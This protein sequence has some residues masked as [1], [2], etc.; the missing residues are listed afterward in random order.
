MASYAVGDLQGCNRELQLLLK[1]IG[2]RPGEDRLVLLGDLVNRGPES[3]AVLRWAYAHREQVEVVLGNHDLHLIAVHAGCERVKSRDTFA[4]VLAAQDAPQLIAW[5]RTQPLARV[6]DERF[7]CVHAGVLPVWSVEEAL[8]LSQEV[9]SVLASPDYKAFLPHLYGNQPDTWDAGLQG[10]PRLRL[11]VNA[12][13]RMRVLDKDGRLELGFKGELADAPAGLQAW[14]DAPH[15][16]PGHWRVLF[17]HWSALGLLL[18]DDVVSLDTGCA[19][20]RSLS[21]LRLD[22]GAVF[23]VPSLQPLHSE[24][25]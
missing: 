6:L 19:W 7:L 10:W 21:A 2:F 17:G 15:R 5:L 4:D 22:D 8:R 12:M 23:Q 1:R 24:K 20:G 9:S 3:L 18:R 11:V 25:D 13:T 16:R 14:F